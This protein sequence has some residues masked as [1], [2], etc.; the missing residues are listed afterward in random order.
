MSVL[1]V[2]STA[3]QDTPR[4]RMVVKRELDELYP[5]TEVVTLGATVGIDMMVWHVV[6]KMSHH[7]RE[8]PDIVGQASAHCTLW[9]PF[10][11]QVANMLWQRET[12][13]GRVID[14]VLLVT[15]NICNEPV[16][17]AVHDLAQK[18]RVYCQVVV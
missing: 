5:N 6:Q 18:N 4:N 11:K 17:L 7:L 3:W 12:L 9:V 10:E 14:K 2:G 8:H 1:I 13:Y 15:T 16:S